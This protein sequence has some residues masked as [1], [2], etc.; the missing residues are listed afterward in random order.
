M[1]LFDEDLSLRQ[2]ISAKFLRAQ[3]LVGLGRLAEGTALLEEVCIL[4]ANHS[5][6][7]DM[8]SV[9]ELTVR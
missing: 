4:D 9:I 6:A 7:A 2:E 3:A 1:L 5:G 8:L